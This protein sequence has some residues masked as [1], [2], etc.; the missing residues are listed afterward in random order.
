MSGFSDML[1]NAPF[2]RLL[3]PFIAGII[4]GGSCPPDLKWLFFALSIGLCL[5]LIFFVSFS[6]KRVF[7]FGV[8]LSATLFFLGIFFSIDNKYH[9]QPLQKKEYYAIVDEFPVEKEKTHRAIVRLIEPKIKILAYIDKSVP[10]KDIGPGCV[11]WFHGQP[12]VLQKTGNPFEFDYAEYSAHN[13]IG[14]RIYLS[15]NNIYFPKADRALNLLEYSLIIRERL[16]KILENS[17]LKGDVLHLV[18][19]V[20]LG[21]REDL[22]PETTQSFSNTGVIHVL[23]VSGMN[24]GII[25]IVLALLLRFLKRRKPGIFFQTIIILTALWGYALITGLSA[26]VLRAAAMFSFIVIGKNLSRSPEIYNILASSAFVLLCFNPFLVYDVGFQLSYAAVFSIVYFHP[27]LYKLLY[28]KYWIPDQIWLLLSVSVSAQ[29]GTL[30]FLLHYFHQFPTWFLL[31]NLMV[32]PLVSLILYLSFIVFAIAPLVPFLGKLMAWVLDLAGQGMLFS[33]HF[34]EKLPFALITGLYPDNPTIIIS[35]LFVIFLG[36][37]IAY[38]SP[39]ALATSLSLVI[40]ILIYYNITQLQTL[41]IKEIVVFNLQGRTL[42]ALTSGRETCWLISK[43]SGSVGK[44]KYYMQPYEGARGIKKSE[45]FSLGDTTRL[46]TNKLASIR[47]FLKFEGITIC[48][49]DNKMKEPVWES[50]PA[51]DLFILSE[52]SSISPGSILQHCPSAI[53]VDNRSSYKKFE[54]YSQPEKRLNGNP[55]LNTAEGAVKISI[56]QSVEGGKSTLVYG[57]FNR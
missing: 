1:H 25:Y 3:V 14:H 47:N 42:V 23:A 51:T 4:L 39:K 27:F 40:I 19:A 18:S 26:S 46:N 38:K 49:P 11:M 31:A 20:A 55:L 21:A 50:F 8:T 2:V 16:I 24:V 41:T 32:I 52:K 5:P 7:M 34:V 45:M 37:F 12:E 15:N 36:A 6:F 54:R 53:I 33:V 43:N 48:V 57:Y 56:G 22:E 35:V 17:G 28:F 44:L 10:L 9:P 13:G 30:P 29:I